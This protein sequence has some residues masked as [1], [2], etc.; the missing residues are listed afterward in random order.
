M[1]RAKR[2]QEKTVT[3]PS[4]EG[5]PDYSY[6]NEESLRILSRGY[7]PEGI[8]KEDLKARAIERINAIVARAEQILD[9]KLPTMRI[10]IRRGWVSP[11][12]P[13]WSNFGT[14]RGLP[15]SCNGSRMGD[16]VDSIVYKVAEIGMMTK[17][18]AGTSAYM[19]DLRPSGS[20]ISGGGT[21]L[22]PVHFARLVQEQVSVISQSN[23]RRG[24]AAIYLP[25]DHPD[26]DEWLK[27]RSITDG[28][29][30]PIQHLSFGV[31]ISDEWM[32]AMLAEQKGG[33]KRKLMAKIVNKRRATG[34]P[35]IVFTGNANKARHPRLK[36]LGLEIVS[37][38]LCMTGD[39][40]VVSSHGL[41]TAKELHDMGGELVLFDGEKAVKASP[42]KLREESADV[43]RVTLANGMEHKI[44]SYHKL[45]VRDAGGK[46]YRMVECKDLKI[47][48]RVEVQ[49]NKG[50]FGTVHEPEAAFLLGLY[51][52][53]GTNAGEDVLI[54]LWD[55]KTAHLEGEIVAALDCLYK[56]F[57]VVSAHNG[58]TYNTPRFGDAT[59]T[60]G[61]VRKRVIRT[62]LLSR[63]FGFA[64][65]VIPGWLWR[66]DE[67][68]VWAYLRGLMLTDGTIHV[69]RN[70]EGNPAQLNVS[71][72][73]LA[74]L[75]DVQLLMRN[76]GLSASIHLLRKGGKSVLPDDRGG[77][78]E[79]DTKDCWRVCVG[80]KNDILEIERN[81]GFLSARGVKIEDRAYRDNSRKV[82][83][84]VSIEYVGKE[85]VYCPTVYTDEHIF[86]AQGMRTGNCSEIMLPL[87]E[88]ESFVCDLSSVNLLHYDEWKDTPLLR[89]M[90]YFLD[91]VMQEYIDKCKQPGRRLLADALR[92]AERW[93]ALGVGVLGYHSLLQQKMIPF[94]SDEARALNIE[95][96]ELLQRETDA[97]SRDMAKEYGEAPGMNGTGQRHLTLRAIAPTRSS[98][99]ILGQV[100]QSIEPWEANIFE[101]DNAKS[102]FVLRN[103]ALESLLEIKGRNDDETWLS[104]ARNAGS[105]QHLDF[106][107]DR[108]KA[109]FKTFVEIDQMEV[110]RQNN[111]RSRFI[112]QGVSLN[113]KIHPDV[114]LADNVKLIVE[115]WKGG[116]KSLYYHKGLS[117]AQERLREAQACAACEA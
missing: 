30:H 100:S 18:G 101:D 33:A 15:I 23:V 50:L 25:V 31:C 41:L 80:S 8:A 115:A 6:L 21:S 36:E 40:R 86:V 109:V 37:S 78:R 73:D 20:P 58:R 104:I 62:R 110:V 90:V 43:W 32:E 52:G 103:R 79:F 105:A 9:R 99:L 72:I 88:N 93:R 81:T 91:A 7:L 55:G 11:S 29:N 44:T 63:Q 57:P 45:P 71:S 102:T 53:D 1:T 22:G 108:E 3:L 27:I 106:L 59:P 24:N 95:I 51:H 107:T 54:C 75:K 82:S 67:E 13:I 46:T 113:L 111:D 26:I 70:A 4:L 10:G 60:Q 56:R 97:A 42:M 77:S 92:F 34:Y 48:D 83:E 76:L 64:K 39:Q 5:R 117:R 94:E 98:S 89:E 84:V 16:S 114:S 74:F 61:G 85:P 12:S 69:S 87:T 19:G 112:D 2:G 35:Y 49:V 65:G 116:T 14:A 96:H 28:V 17:E 47:G 38:N 66:A 68:T